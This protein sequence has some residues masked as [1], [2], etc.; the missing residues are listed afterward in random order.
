MK[1][2]YEVED[3][4]GRCVKFHLLHQNDYIGQIVTSSH[5][6]QIQV[7]GVDKESQ[8]YTKIYGYY[9]LTQ[10]AY[11]KGRL[12]NGEMLKMEA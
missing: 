5:Y 3:L 2:L 7:I 1:G 9:T 6:G 10:V 12:Q 4:P 8:P 11:G